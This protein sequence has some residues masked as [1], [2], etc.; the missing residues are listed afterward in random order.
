MQ[1]SA[2]TTASFA[3]YPPHAR[4]VAQAH[5]AVLQQLPLAFLPSLLRELIEYDFKF[6]VEQ[7]ELDRQLDFLSART[8]LQRADLFAAFEQIHLTSDLVVMDWCNRPIDFTEELSAFLWRSHQMSAFRAAAAAYGDRLQA[9]LPR[10]TLPLTRL[11]IAVIGRGATPR[12]NTP[13]FT[14]LRAHGTCFSNVDPTGGLDALLDA[15]EDRARRSSAPYAHWYVDGGTARAHSGLITGISWA[16]L[17]P[18]RAA[19]LNRI[20]REISKA[21]MGPEELRD[22]LMHLA[23]ADLG[24]ANDPVLDHFQLKVLTEGSGAQIFSTTFVQWTAREALRRA[25]ALTLLVRFAPRQRERPMNELLTNNPAPLELDAQGS[26]IDADMAAYYQWINQQ[27]LSG[28]AEAAF[29]VWFE[30]QRQAIAIGPTLPRGAESD[31]RLTV[32]DVLA[33]ATG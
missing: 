8:P 15:V 19:L 27:R 26:L 5:V 21:G 17:E 24:L 11:G 32:S 7:T 3:S 18:T 12:E 23:P 33:L 28:S 6:P 20:G 10:Q 31:S 9:E 14:K 2:L 30:D 22:H 1:T 16:A 13:L 29:L 25:E 4:A